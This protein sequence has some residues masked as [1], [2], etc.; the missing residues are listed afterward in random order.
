MEFSK[1]NNID[2]CMGMIQDNKRHVDSEQ[3]SANGNL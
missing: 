2:L 1:K 3:T